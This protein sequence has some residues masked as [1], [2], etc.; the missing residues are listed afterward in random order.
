M[1]KTIPVEWLDLASNHEK[2]TGLPAGV[3]MNIIKR[4]TGL[5]QRFLD[6]PSAPHY[7]VGPN[8][9][10]PKSSARGLGGIL[11]G[12]ARDPGYGVSPLKDWSVP[13][14]IRFMADYLSARSKNAGSLEAGLG[15][16]GEG[17]KYAQGV[18]NKLGNTQVA[19]EPQP[20]NPV[21]STQAVAPVV[22][23]SN[24]APAAPVMMG[25]VAP[26]QG[27]EEPKPVQVAM[28]DGPSFQLPAWTV[29]EISMGDMNRLMNNHV[30]PNFR[31]FNKWGKA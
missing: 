9:E 29:P 18:L 20:A 30:T 7:F 8:G 26:Q 19:P 24:P 23:A 11:E 2:R 14:Q 13:E 4:E 22:V 28:N 16:Y 6:D 31:A 3:L 17:Q 21:A 1:A 10:K 15:G 12:T 25:Y 5:Q 27:M